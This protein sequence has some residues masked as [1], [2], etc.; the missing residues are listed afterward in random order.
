MFLL[1]FALKMAI[2]NVSVCVC[3]FPVIQCSFEVNVF[4]A[5][6]FFEKRLLISIDYSRINLLKSPTRQTCIPDI[7]CTILLGLNFGTT[8]FTK[9]LIFY[10]N[11]CLV[12]FNSCLKIKC[13]FFL[14]NMFIIKDK[15]YY[16]HHCIKWCH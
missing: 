15:L 12:H 3:N 13:W 16:Y 11:N 1:W 10:L 8:I 2:K 14:I 6:I 9:S 7:H 5:M 4:F